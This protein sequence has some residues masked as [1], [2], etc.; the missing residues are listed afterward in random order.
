MP[1]GQ[2][3]ISSQYFCSLLA[4]PD[5]NW[6]YQN[7]SHNKIKVTSTPTEQDSQMTFV[8]EQFKSIIAARSVNRIGT[9]TPLCSLKCFLNDI[10]RLLTRRRAGSFNRKWSTL[11]TGGWEQDTHPSSLWEAKC[12]YNLLWVM[13]SVIVQLNNMC[14]GGKGHRLSQEVVCVCIEEIIEIEMKI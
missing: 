14:I 4:T 8:R 1:S 3:A 11:T 10:T 5:H 7:G 12:N 9:R 13:W 2:K 6:R